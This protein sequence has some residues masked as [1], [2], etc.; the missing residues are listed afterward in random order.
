[1]RLELIEGGEVLVDDPKYVGWMEGSKVVMVVPVSGY[2]FE[3]VRKVGDEMEIGLPKRGK[4]R[5]AEVR[6]IRMSA[7]YWKVRTGMRLKIER[8]GEW[9]SLAMSVRVRRIY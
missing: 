7:Y 9:V 4:Y 3:R 2:G 6:K 5:E 1:M 8:E